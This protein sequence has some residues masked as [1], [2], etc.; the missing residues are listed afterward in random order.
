MS[1]YHLTKIKK[2]EIG[3]ISKV[4]EECHE[5][6]DA[7]NQNC[8]IMETLELSDIYGALE[9]LAE[10]YNLSMS[11]LKTMSDITKRAFKEGKR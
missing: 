4:L 2:G 3:D 8:K 1:G 10:T 11:D 9:L 6:I 5:Y 7:K